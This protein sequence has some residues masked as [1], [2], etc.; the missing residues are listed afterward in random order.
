MANMKNFACD[1]VM[2]EGRWKPGYAPK[3]DYFIAILHCLALFNFSTTQRSL[4]RYYIF[5]M[6]SAWWKLIVP[7]FYGVPMKRKFEILGSHDAR[8]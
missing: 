4:P 3:L 6:T 7:L 8:V 1:H 2:N 5:N